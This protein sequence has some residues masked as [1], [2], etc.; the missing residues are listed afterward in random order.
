MWILTRLK[1]NN[2]KKKKKE[3]IIFESH[4]KQHGGRKGKRIN[5]LAA[6]RNAQPGPECMNT[7]VQR[8]VFIRVTSE[9]ENKNSQRKITMT[10]TQTTC[11]NRIALRAGKKGARLAGVRALKN[12]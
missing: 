5:P 4:G 11:P 7:T 6:Q 1:L 9:E 12:L 10:H 8:P 3:K 2:D